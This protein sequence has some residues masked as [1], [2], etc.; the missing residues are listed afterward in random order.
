MKKM[1]SQ[2]WFG[3]DN[4]DGFLYRSWMKNQGWPHDLLMG[5]RSL[6]FATPGRS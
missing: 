1:R 4:R 2:A 6:G 5:V 3:R